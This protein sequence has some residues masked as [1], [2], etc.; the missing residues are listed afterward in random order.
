MTARIHQ[1]V[2]K[3]SSRCNL[4]CTYCYVYNTGD[5]SWRDRPAVMSDDVFLAT[6]QR[7]RI[8]CSTSNPAHASIS[9]H[10]GEPTLV[11]AAKFDRWCGL[12]KKV[13][14]RLDGY[15]ISLQTNGTLLDDAWVTVLDRHSVRV[16][17]SLDGPAHINDKNRVFRKGGGSYGAVLRGISLL[18]DRQIPFGVLTVVRLGE[19][20]LPIHDHLLSLAPNTISYLLP[21]LNYETIGDVRTRFGPTPCADFLIPIFDAW[22]KAGT[23]QVRVRDLWN[24]CR[25]VLGGES[26]IESIGGRP[27][28]YAFVETD[29]G[30]EAL[31]ALKSCGPGFTATGLN[32]LRN[33]FSD[34]AKHELFQVRTIYRG[35][36][37]PKACGRCAERDTCHGGY[38]PHRYRQGT[39]FDNPSVWCAD[40]IKLFSHIRQR[41]GVPVEETPRVRDLV[42]TV[43]RARV[44]ALYE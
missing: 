15:Q 5:T 36:P 17:I 41:L 39:D 32:V 35:T 27:T 6:L 20:P 24:I 34:L 11:G 31:D 25:V 13:L 21:D 4:N 38:L 33:E 42:D 40:L 43:A 18:R 9:F 10:G 29:G 44:S 16:G 2:V 19:S 30:I 8:E 14:S 23:T 7:I 26:E 1:F 37:L 12:T 28:L 22:W 3:V